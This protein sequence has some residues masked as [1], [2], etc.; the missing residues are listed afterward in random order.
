MLAGLDTEFFDLA[1]PRVFAHR[2]ASGDRPENTM[3]A[4]DGAVADGAPYIELDVHM[5]RDG[6][7]VV[8]HD[9]DLRRVSDREG[10]ITELRLGKVQ[11]AD[12]AYSFSPDGQSYPFRGQ[13]LRV[14]TLEEVLRAFPRQRFIIE[15]KQVAPSLIAPALDVIDRAGMRRRVLV[16][17]EHQAPLDEV[18]RLAPDLATNFSA[19]EVGA[20]FKSM[21]PGADP[22]VPTSAAL[23]IP[24]EHLSWKLATP[25]SVAAAHRLGVEVHVWTVNEEAEML[26]MLEIGVD[27]IITDYPARLLKLIGPFARPAPDRT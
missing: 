17:S 24:P 18:R 25:E 12:A 21:A 6:V 23:Q 9:E 5:T 1:L 22:Y 7:V 14:P 11:S 8:I 2:G 20:F 15:V 4:F 13:G 16:A 26:R 10:V 19:A 3:A 27:G